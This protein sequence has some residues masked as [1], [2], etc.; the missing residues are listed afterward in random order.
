M[1]GKSGEDVYLTIDR[2]VQALAD[3]KLGS[4]SAAMVVMDVNNGDVIALSSTPG[5]DP[6]WFNVRA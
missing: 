3:Q 5:F 6:N 1:P 2:Q 4:E